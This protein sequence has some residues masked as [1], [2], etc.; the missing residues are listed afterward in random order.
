MLAAV[1][2][3]GL[4]REESLASLADELSVFRTLMSIFM[5]AIPSS[6]WESYHLSQSTQGLPLS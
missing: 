1:W 5:D 3:D 4:S 2:T 6:N